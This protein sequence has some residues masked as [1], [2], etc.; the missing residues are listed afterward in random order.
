[1]FKLK[2]SVH[3]L[4]LLSL[5]FLQGCNLDGPE[6]T[7]IDFDQD[8]QTQVDEEDETISNVIITFQCN[9]NEVIS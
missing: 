3:L 9:T 1:M 6:Q 5:L 7:Q 4:T 8:D 2:L